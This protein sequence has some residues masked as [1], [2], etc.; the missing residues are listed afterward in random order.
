MAWRSDDPKNEVLYQTNKMVWDTSARSQPANLPD[1]ELAW[2]RFVTDQQ[3][4]TQNSKSVPSR[5]W[6]IAAV[7][8]LAISATLWYFNTDQSRLEDA[9]TVIT[10]NDQHTR[11]VLADGSTVEL[12][13]GI[14]L[15]DHG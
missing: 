10:A 1:P 11:Q 7:L 15:D 2:K 12:K 8:I 4:H 13:N 5:F 3:I 14:N 6:R 9:P